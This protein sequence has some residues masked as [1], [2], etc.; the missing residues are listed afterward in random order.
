M[1][2][3]NQKLLFLGEDQSYMIKS[4]TS[5]FSLWSLLNLK[6]MIWFDTRKTLIRSIFI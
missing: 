4:G 1:G 2:I 6:K 3:Y 5:L